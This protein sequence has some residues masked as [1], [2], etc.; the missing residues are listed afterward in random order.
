MSFPFRSNFFNKKGFF[1]LQKKNLS[2]TIHKNIIPKKI[3]AIQFVKAPFIGSFLKNLQT[4]FF[5]ASKRCIHYEIDSLPFGLN[6]TNLRTNVSA[7]KDGSKNLV[8]SVLNKGVDLNQTLSS[9]FTPM[10]EACRSGNLE[11]VSL[12]LEHGADINKSTSDTGITPLLVAAAA[13]QSSVVQLLLDKG[14]QIDKARSDNGATPLY[15]AAR[16]GHV[17]V[18][19]LLLQRGADPNKATTD[20]KKTPLSIACELNHLKIVEE[21]VANKKCN[22][23]ATRFD[24]L[25]PLVIACAMGHVRIVETLLRCGANPNAYFIDPETRLN[26]TPLNFSLL[27]TKIHM[28]DIAKLLLNYGADVEEAAMSYITYNNIKRGQQSVN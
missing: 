12:L 1:A 10:L 5:S 6:T 24:G 18:V 9:D 25:S 16:E 20:T 11:R 17:N 3:L 14:A 2:T 26:S 23:E 8:M 7:I 13:G 28:S 27:H 4:P 22:L 19:K 21:L 15:E